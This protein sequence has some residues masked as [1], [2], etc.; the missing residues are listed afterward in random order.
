MS[1]RE[2]INQLDSQNLKTND[3]LYAIL[4]ELLDKV[5][6]LEQKVTELSVTK[7]N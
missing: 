7:H 2:K 6:V 3:T 5:E 4:E 1:L